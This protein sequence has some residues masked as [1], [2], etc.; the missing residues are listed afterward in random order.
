MGFRGDEFG[1]RVRKSRKWTDVKDGERVLSV[2]HTTHRENNRDEMEA[3]VFE[4][5]R[6]TG[7]GEVL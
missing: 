5:R 4:Q 6:G 1:D 7:F 2:I 3:G